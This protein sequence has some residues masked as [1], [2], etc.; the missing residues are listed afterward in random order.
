MDKDSE[1][2][3]LEILRMAR[4]LVI[5]EHTDR[6]AQLHNTWLYESNQ[7]WQS[8][9]MKL[10]YPDIP[11]YPTEQDVLERAQTLLKFLVLGNTETP[12]REIV[13][14]TTLQEEAL[15][16]PVKTVVEESEPQIIEESEPQ[17]IEEPSV[18]LLREEPSGRILP[19]VLK[20]IEK[21]RNKF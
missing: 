3:L 18:D 5:N 4:E 12:V 10:K 20:Q 6:R 16:E 11:P 7:L 1:K 19:A 14:P 9:R 2:S 13:L 21:M 17:I 8:R 15:P